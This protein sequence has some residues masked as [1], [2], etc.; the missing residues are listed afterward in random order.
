DQHRLPRP[1][2]DVHRGGSPQ[3]GRP[4]RARAGRPSDLARRPG[5][6]RRPPHRPGLCRGGERDRGHRERDRRRPGVRARAADPARGGAA[7]PPAPPGP[8]WPGTRPGRARRVVPRG[9]CP[10]P[11]VLQRPA[12][13]RPGGGGVVH[14]RCRPHGRRRRV[15]LPL[16]RHR[17]PPRR[18]AVRP[19]G[20]GRLDRGPSRERHPVRA[21][22]PGRG[23]PARAHR[24]RPHLDR[25]LPA[26]QRPWLTARHPRRVR[27]PRPRPDQA[28]EP[29]PQAGPGPVLLPDRRGRPHRRRGRRRLPAPGPRVTGRGQAPGLL[30]RRRRGQRRPPSRGHPGVRGGAGVGRRLAPAHPPL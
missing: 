10:V 11:A 27:G 12:A 30:P 1:A 20:A 22:G 3:R 19:R 28:G 16:G 8:C 5:C 26:P 4:G 23:R 14:L 2:G 21:R 6:R 17:H 24:A 29:A 25:A 13:W 18:Q 15:P 9:P 7:G